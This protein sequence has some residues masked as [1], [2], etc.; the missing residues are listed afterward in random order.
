MHAPED[1]RS[2]LVGLSGQLIECLSGTS[3][4]VMI[5]NK[6]IHF[7]YARPVCSDGDPRKI[8]SQHRFTIFEWRRRDVSDVATRWN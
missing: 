2:C 5:R 4:S 8:M 1:G 6:L 7:W 3:T